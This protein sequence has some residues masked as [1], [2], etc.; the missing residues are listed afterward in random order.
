MNKVNKKE[1]KISYGSDAYLFQKTPEEVVMVSSEEDIKLVCEDL[2]NNKKKFCI[3]AAGTGYTGAS[4]PIIK[5]EVVVKLLGFNKIISI[6]KENRYIDVEAGVTPFKIREYANTYE[7][8][9]PPDPASFKVCSIGGNIVTNAGGPHCYMYGVTSNYVQKI[10]CFIPKY[11]DY[12]EIG[13]ESPYSLDYDLKDLFIGSEGL[14]GV[15]T[16]ARLKL[17]PKPPYMYTYLIYFDKYLNA[18]KFIYN[19]IKHSLIFASLDM[20]VDPYIPEIDDISHIGAYLLISIHGGD[21]YVNHAK[22]LLNKLIK[23]YTCEYQ[24]SDGEELMAYRSNLVKQN[25]RKIIRL[26]KKP[27]YFLFDA[28]VPRSRLGVVLEFSYKLANKLKIPLMNTFHAGDG[29]IHPTIFYDP[30]SPDDIKKIRI[31][32]YNLLKTVL[33][34]GGSITGEHGIGLEKREIYTYHENET[35]LGI[36]R[37]IKS[38]FDHYF[39]LNNGKVFVR[40]TIDL[41]KKIEEL[42]KLTKDDFTSLYKAK[43]V[44]LNA[45]DISI[46]DGVIEVDTEE[47]FHN[48]VKV[49]DQYDCFMPYSP[50]AFQD[51]SLLFLIKNNI[52]SIFS[53]LFDLK[54]ILLGMKFVYKDE[55][56]VVRKKVL[57]NVAGFSL[58]FLANFDIIGSPKSFFF[59]VFPTSYK[60]KQYIIISFAIN[61]VYKI[62][63]IYELIKEKI[64]SF[65]VH[66]KGKNYKINIILYN[67]DSYITTLEKTLYNMNAM[68]IKRTYLN[69]YYSEKELYKGIIVVGFTSSVKVEHLEKLFEGKVDYTFINNRILTIFD[70]KSEYNKLLER[71][72]SSPLKSAI[73]SI[74]Y[75]DKKVSSKYIFLNKRLSYQ[76]DIM[77]KLVNHIKDYLTSLKEETPQGSISASIPLINLYPIPTNLHT[78]IKEEI[79]KCTRCGLCLSECPQYVQTG[80]EKVSLRGLIL[81]LIGNNEV[82]IK[83]FISYCNHNCDLKNPPCELACPTGV[84]FSKILAIL[85]G[86]TTH[87]GEIR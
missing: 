83:N 19:S 78:A 51:A 3:R 6:D 24:S 10:K 54:D 32:W 57:K 63:K 33:S 66:K 28:V 27:Q 25:V 26:S 18:V 9:Y 50:A 49:I 85:I 15:V 8:F 41:Q 43:K 86:N 56:I 36:S 84:S 2:I 12:I 70:P 20:S 47:E 52:P 76:V 74:R 62:D 60:S 72:L 67:H 46:I 16:R 81:S 65:A 42:D 14:L 64:L 7:L 39:L 11:H 29:N 30:Y 59:K 58:K 23:K 87:E 34:L 75:I 44:K 1:S 35:I 17:I 77:S 69:K 55:T 53:P 13:A 4:I 45:F 5:D 79:K 73:E 48:I 71:L 82:I 31:F 40:K 37:A 22:P 68:Y 80:N 38:F 21:K 61:E